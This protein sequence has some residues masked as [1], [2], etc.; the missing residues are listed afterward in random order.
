MSKIRA[1]LLSFGLALILIGIFLISTSTEEKI[2]PILKDS[3]EFSSENVTVISFKA[4]KELKQTYD[5]ILSVQL[6]PF[7]VP[8]NYTQSPIISMLLVDKIGFSKIRIGE[9]PETTLLTVKGLYENKTFIIKNLNGEKELYLLASSPLP[10]IQHA[11]IRVYERFEE[12]TMSRKYLGI[13]TCI[14][15]LI[16]IS[17]SIVKRSKSKVRKKRSIHSHFKAP[18]NR[19]RHDLKHLKTTG[20][21]SVYPLFYVNLLLNNPFSFMPIR[22][23][24]SGLSIN[25]S[26]FSAI[27]FKFQDCTKNPL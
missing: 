16:S 5:L 26:I 6:K 27:P 19:L 10:I 20:Y 23:A 12:Y 7:F 4:G 22:F 3:I 15:G 2:R 13:T 25:Q 18:S 14:A 8:P 17:I 9:I 24:S 1:I 11:T 21:D